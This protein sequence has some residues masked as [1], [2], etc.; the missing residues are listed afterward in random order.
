MWACSS[1]T[2][3]P[4]RSHRDFLRVMIEKHTVQPKHKLSFPL[5]YSRSINLVKTHSSPS[6]FL[7]FFLLSFFIFEVTLKSPS[8]VNIGRISFPK[9]LS[10]CSTPETLYLVPLLSFTT[11]VSSVDLSTDPEPSDPYLSQF[12]L[13]S[14]F[15]PS[16]FPRLW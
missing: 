10:P 6:I 16:D 7:H 1:H 14:E 11:Y 8:N 13:R 5:F 9:R 12:L 15:G 3:S 2:T 4:A